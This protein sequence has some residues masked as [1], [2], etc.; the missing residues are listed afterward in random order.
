MKPPLLRACLLLAAA[1]GHRL[2]P[3]END[4]DLGIAKPEVT[5][6]LVRGDATVRVWPPAGPGCDELVAV[7]GRFAGATP[8]DGVAPTCLDVAFRLARGELGSCSE[9][10]R[11]LATP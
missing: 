10:V 5:I 4:G 1:C 2:R 7:C 3:V 8:A 6:D 11:S 9:A